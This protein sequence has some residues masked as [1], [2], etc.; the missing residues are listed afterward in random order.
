MRKLKNKILLIYLVLSLGIIPYSLLKSNNKN[1]NEAFNNDYSNFSK[2]TLSAPE[3]AGCDVA[4]WTNIYHPESGESH[5]VI[6]YIPN[7]YDPNIPSS[8]LYA[9][10]GWTQSIEPF[11]QESKCYQIAQN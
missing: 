3:Y 5:H 6:V 9:C 8:V 10:H 7:T 11:I 2:L 1:F 4:E